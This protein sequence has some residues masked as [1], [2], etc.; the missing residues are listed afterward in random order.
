MRVTMI[1]KPLRVVAETMGHSMTD[2]AVHVT[3]IVGLLLMYIAACLGVKLFGQNDPSHFGDLPVAFLTLFRILTAEDASYF[4][5][6]NMY[7]CDVYPVQIGNTNHTCDHPKAQPVIAN[8]Y[9]KMYFCS[10]AIVVVAL[11]ISI[12]L[13]V[14][15]EMEKRIVG[16][17]DK[18][19]VDQEDLQ[20]TRQ[21]QKESS[22]VHNHQALLSVIRSVD[23]KIESQR[24][25]MSQIR[26]RLRRKGF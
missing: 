5:Y 18:A 4:M 25:Q 9:F 23:G 17:A 7:G 20:R 19:T 13:E 8:L 22:K 3:L 14:R 21:Q 16:K 1:A 24:E 15:E 2:I 12:I 11:L 10:T 6:P 26:N